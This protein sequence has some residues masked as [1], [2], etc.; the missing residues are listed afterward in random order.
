[1][2]KKGGSSGMKEDSERDFLET[3][4]GEG[5]GERRGKRRCNS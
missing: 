3:E 2:R 5:R 4:E 1:M